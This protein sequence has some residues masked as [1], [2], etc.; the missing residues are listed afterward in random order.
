MAFST[1][2][3]FFGG[4]SMTCRTCVEKLKTCNSFKGNRTTEWLPCPL[5]LSRS[6]HRTFSCKTFQGGDYTTT[7]HTYGDSHR[8][9]Q[10]SAISE[11]W[12]DWITS[13]NIS[14]EPERCSENDSLWR[15]L[16]SY[17]LCIF[18][19]W[20]I[21]ENKMCTP[22]DMQNVAAFFYECESGAE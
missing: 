17:V 15:C 19:W 8:T 21:W 7:H 14:T 3:R 2:G 1:S 22:L 5:L 13:R 12:F 9:N 20:G 18:A 4:S 6:N 10:R 11:S 16:I